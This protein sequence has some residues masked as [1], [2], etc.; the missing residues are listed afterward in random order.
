MRIPSYCIISLCSNEIKTLMLCYLWKNV[1]NGGS[2]V[3]VGIEWPQFL[4]ADRKNKSMPTNATNYKWS[5]CQS[6]IC[7][8][9]F[10]HFDS[11]TSG[12]SAQ[13]RKWI[14]GREKTLMWQSFPNVTNSEY[15]WSI[16]FL[17]WYTGWLVATWE[18]DWKLRST[19]TTYP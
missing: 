3:T 2:V 9:F 5:Q 7:L 14:A 17:L 8:G 18:P 1:L 11:T 12:L 16:I 15:M 19:N 10:F 6:Q 4:W 13:R